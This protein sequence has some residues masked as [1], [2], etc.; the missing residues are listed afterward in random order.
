[1]PPARWQTHMPPI[2]GPAKSFPAPERQPLGG[3]GR[4]VSLREFACGIIQLL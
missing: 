1:M 3:A 4:A 2:A